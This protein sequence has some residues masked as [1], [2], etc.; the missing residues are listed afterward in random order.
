MNTAFTFI[1]SNRNNNIMDQQFCCYS[2]AKKAHK[3]EGQGNQS[4]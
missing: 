4:F 1:P 3:L 2:V